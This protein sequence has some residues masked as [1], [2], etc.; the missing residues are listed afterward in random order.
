MYLNTTNGVLALSVCFS[1][2]LESS[3][4]SAA[5]HN[6]WHFLTSWKPPSVYHWSLVLFKDCLAWSLMKLYCECTDQFR[7]KTG[8][9]WQKDHAKHFSSFQ[10]QNKRDIK[11]FLRLPKKKFSSL[12]VSTGSK[13]I[14]ESLEHKTEFRQKFKILQKVVFLP[15]PNYCF[16]R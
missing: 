11:T 5:N 12:S 3:H 15:S 7:Y 16:E 1:I 4:H 8:E 14:M 13:F 10:T 6:I 9:V 2:C